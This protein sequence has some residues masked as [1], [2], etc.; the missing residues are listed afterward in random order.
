[1]N[2]CLSLYAYSIN[3]TLYILELEIDLEL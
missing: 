1:L 2:P 3:K